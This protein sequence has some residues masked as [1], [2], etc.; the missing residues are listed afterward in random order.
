[1]S[2]QALTRPIGWWLKEADARLDAAFDVALE[3]EGVDRR[4]WQVLASLSR[5]PSPRAQLVSALTSFD[6]PVVVDR[7]IDDLSSRGWI[8]DTA[9]SLQLTQA[10]SSQYAGLAPLVDDVRGR[11]AA[12]LSEEEYVVLVGLLSRLVAAL[13]PTV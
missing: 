3:S 11:V 2:E 1:M 4:G 7:V 9:D 13:P 5:G 6:P 12:A 8:D 10:G